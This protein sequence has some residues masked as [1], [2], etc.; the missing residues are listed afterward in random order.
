MKPRLVRGGNE[1]RA[2]RTGKG[3]G[4]PGARIAP[5]VKDSF[6]NFYSGIIGILLP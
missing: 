1:D 4:I 6:S 3:L 2:A 5:I